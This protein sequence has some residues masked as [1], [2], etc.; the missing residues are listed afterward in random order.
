ERLHPDDRGRVQATFERA[1]TE[2]RPTFLIQYRCVWPDGSIHWLDCRAQVT[3][4]DDDAVGFQGLLL[5]L[6]RDVGELGPSIPTG[7]LDAVAQRSAARAIQI[8]AI[9][10]GLAGA[11]SRDEVAR[12]VVDSLIPA[13]EAQTGSLFLV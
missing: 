5:H 10:A 2:K 6:D 9:T 3:V 1:I 11:A 8:E 12:I 7:V 4:E 13:V